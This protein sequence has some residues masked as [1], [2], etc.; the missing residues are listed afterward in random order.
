[1]KDAPAEI[2]DLFEELETLSAVLTQSLSTNPDNVFDAV[3]ESALRRCKGKISRLRYKILK[4]LRDP[5][6]P[7][8]R[9]RIW[10]SIK[11][12]PDQPFFPAYP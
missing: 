5:N 11:T 4:P 6:S 10:A 9:K 7:S 3:A 1:V 8:L 2:N 12:A